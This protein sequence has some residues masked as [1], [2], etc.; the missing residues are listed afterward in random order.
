MASEFFTD[1]E[2]VVGA[3]TTVH[4][5]QSLIR[6]VPNLPL[7]RAWLAGLRTQESARPARLPF[8]RCVYGGLFSHA[9]PDHAGCCATFGPGR[10]LK[11]GRTFLASGRYKHFAIAARDS[12]SGPFDVA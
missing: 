1:D 5:M 8:Q 12:I 10:S 11:G 3:P 2:V 7:P 9:E 4:W 6:Q